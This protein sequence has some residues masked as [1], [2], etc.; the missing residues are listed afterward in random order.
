MQHSALS[1]FAVPEK[2]TDV[3]YRAHSA[4]DIGNVPGDVETDPGV[5]N[6]G[7]GDEHIKGGGDQ[8]DPAPFAFVVFKHP[9]H[10]GGKG[11]QGQGLVGPGEVSPQ[12][13][14]A[15]ER[16]RWRLEAKKTPGSTG[17]K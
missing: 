11:K 14:E 5:G 16:I 8:R 15:G 4:D 1:L 10:D 7:H 13:V 6:V 17:G 2:E 12:G 9:D 3:D